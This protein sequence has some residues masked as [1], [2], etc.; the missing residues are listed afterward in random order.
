MQTYIVQPGDTL[1]GISK[2]FGV[3]VEEIRLANNLISN[4]IIPLQVLK[5]PTST[6]VARYVVR[7][8]DTL[9]KIAALYDTTVSELMNINNL[10]STILSIGQQ[11][12]VPVSEGEEATGTFVYTVKA[13]DSLYS[14]ANNYSTTVDEIKRLNN[15]TSNLISVGQKLRIPVNSTSIPAGEFQTYVVQSGD[16]LYKIA[17]YFDMS[18]DELKR[19]NNL[20]S[21]VLSIGQVLKVKAKKEEQIPSKLE[22][23]GEGYVEPKFETYT[24]KS[25]DSLYSIAKRYDTTVDE[26]VSLNDLK[27][28]SLSIGQVLKIKEIK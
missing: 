16:T 23:Y 7:A 26:L 1:Y 12:L 22:C 20:T 3:T 4:N 11:L 5:I 18:A 21:S 2:Q 17:S 19:L 24:V 8:G 28:N 25:G 13:G 6:T 15:L 9:Y 27:N 14:I 10:K